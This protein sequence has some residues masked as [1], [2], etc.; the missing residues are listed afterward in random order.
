MKLGTKVDAL[1]PSE[2]WGE[3]TYPIVLQNQG[4]KS[5]QWSLG[6]SRLTDPQEGSEERQQREVTVG[7]GR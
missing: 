6:W 4:P 5:V 1:P 7:V 2:H 3:G